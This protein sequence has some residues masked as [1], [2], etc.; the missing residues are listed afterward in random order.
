M[1]IV[2]LRCFISHSLAPWKV[3]QNKEHTKRNNDAA[4]SWF[5]LKSLQMYSKIFIANR[6]SDKNIMCSAANQGA[7]GRGLNAGL[8][9]KDDQRQALRAGDQR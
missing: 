9:T 5:Q 4:K 1:T 6:A 2:L 7:P 8:A 3:V